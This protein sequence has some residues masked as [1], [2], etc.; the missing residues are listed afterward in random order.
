MGGGGYIIHAFTFLHVLE[1]NE[2]FCFGFYLVGKK[3]IIFM[4][5][6]YTPPLKIC[7]KIIE[8]N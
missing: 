1:Q 8:N 6:G 4:D 7:I 3:I 5:E 2:H